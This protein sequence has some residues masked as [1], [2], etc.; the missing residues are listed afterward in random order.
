[1]RTAVGYHRVYEVLHESPGFEMTRAMVRKAHI[2]ERISSAQ[3]ATA[4]CP[5]K[6]R[7]G[8]YSL[9]G[10]AVQRG[11][12]SGCCSKVDVVYNTRSLGSET[13]YIELGLALFVEISRMN[14]R[15]EAGRVVSGSGCST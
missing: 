11:S 5:I 1:M 6:T 2:L 15:E 12:I 3:R 4:C 9:N 7:L 14:P 13:L 10:N 8:R